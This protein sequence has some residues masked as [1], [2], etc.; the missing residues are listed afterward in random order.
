MRSG[1]PIPGNPWP[2]DMIITVDD[3]PQQLLELLWVR[4]TWSLAAGHPDPPPSLVQAAPAGAIPDDGWAT[5]NA[6]WSGLWQG[7]VEHAG[8]VIGA[9][10]HAKLTRPNLAP[11]E[12]RALLAQIVGPN[13][14][15]QFGD[16]GLGDAYQSWQ[17]VHQRNRGAR[18]RELMSA[19]LERHALDELAP[20][21]KR[22]LTKIVTIP[23]RGDHTR[24]IGA[25]TLLVTDETREDLGRYR[26]GL[27]TF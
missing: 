13:W 14:R 19:E 17:A 7:A 23:C 4:D 24:T 26:R 1:W 6:A 15:D 18:R 25:H 20:A 2:H 9:D 10:A 21:W 27:A 16:E 5:W 22:G 8:R 11:P 3:R 12:R